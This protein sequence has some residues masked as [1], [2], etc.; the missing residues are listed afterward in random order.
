[1]FSLLPSSE[2][3]VPRLQPLRGGRQS[4]LLCDPVVARFVAG[5]VQPLIGPLTNAILG[6]V[7]LTSTWF[8]YSFGERRSDV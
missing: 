7:L 1:M 8:V 5:Q 2:R 3:I 6:L 4:Q